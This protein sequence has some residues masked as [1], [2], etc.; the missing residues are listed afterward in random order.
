MKIAIMGSGGLGSYY[1]T[2]L[3]L[4]GN[5]VSF[6]A[7]G[8]HLKAMQSKGLILKGPHITQKLENLNAT[9]NPSEI[10]EVDVVLFCVKLY[11]IEKACKI[12]TPLVN[13][14]T[15]IISV[16]NGINAPE[17]IQK[18]F[19]HTKVFGGAARVSAKIEK[20][21]V[22]K[23]LG[24]SDTSALIFG[25]N[26][27]NSNKLAV[28]FCQSCNNAGFSTQIANNI[29]EILWDKMA[30]L[31]YVAGLTTLA[32]ISIDEAMKIPEL[33]NIGKLLL[34]EVQLV[35]KAKNI[36]INENI[37]E[38]KIKIISNFPKGLYASMYHDL[39]AGKKIELQDIFGYISKEGYENNVPTPVSDF[40]YAFLKPYIN[41]R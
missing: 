39:M 15:L 8:Q 20:P 16:L 17:R 9:D 18:Q 31:C 7:R 36:P 22:I 37:V 1:G 10:G 34:K 25:S 23:H 28:E 29:E 21:G 13:K 12:I 30:H 32:R 19:F 5:K 41:G 4:S 26:K 14:D 11:D 3:A 24:T 33:F 40:I 35:A 27:Y 2:H 38:D 6:I